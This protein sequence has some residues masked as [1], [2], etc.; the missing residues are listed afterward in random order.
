MRSNGPFALM[1]LNQSSGPSPTVIEFRRGLTIG[2][3]DNPASLVG[4]AS[5]GRLEASASDGMVSLDAQLR[6]SP[7]PGLC[8]VG[9]IIAAVASGWVPVGGKIV[10]AAM[11]MWVGNIQPYVSRQKQ[12]APILHNLIQTVLAAG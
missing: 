3:P 12:I 7:W 11:V 9:I 5:S 6:I 1:R 8:S 10:I 2:S 4:I